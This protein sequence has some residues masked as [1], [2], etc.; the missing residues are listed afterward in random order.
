MDKFSWTLR[1]LFLYL[2]YELTQI[3]LTF[4]RTDESLLEEVNE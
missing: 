2:T 1:P 3:F 4:S